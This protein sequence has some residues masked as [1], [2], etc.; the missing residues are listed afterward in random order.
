MQ[1]LGQKPYVHPDKVVGMGAAQR[2]IPCGLDFRANN[3]VRHGL[4]C[5]LGS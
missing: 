2:P 4:V 3:V 1:V 5:A